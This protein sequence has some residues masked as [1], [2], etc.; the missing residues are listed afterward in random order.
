DWLDADDEPRPLGAEIDYYSGLSPAYACKNGPLE[1]VEELLLVRGVTPRLLF[2]MDVNRN[3]MIDPHEQLDGEEQVEV[4]EGAER[5]WSA[6]LA[7]YSL[8]N[9]L[10]PDGQPRVY[11][12][13]N[14]MAKLHEEL[15]SVLPAD[16][17]TFIV[18]YRQ[19]GPYTGSEQGQ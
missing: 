4:V 18:A 14:D 5:G 7:L 9:N 17:A 6:F 12:N 19:N 11:L 10:R 3:G 16:W 8:E 13:Q 2:G 1:T 15:S